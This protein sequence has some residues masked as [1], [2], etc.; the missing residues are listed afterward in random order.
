M[1]SGESISIFQDIYTL[2][3]DLGRAGRAVKIVRECIAA[4][5]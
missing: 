1:T 5:R 2:K 4:A 3:G